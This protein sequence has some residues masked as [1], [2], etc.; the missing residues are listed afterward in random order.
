MVFGI[1]QPAPES[2]PDDG[3]ICIPQDVQRVAVVWGAR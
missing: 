2:G 3:A 1:A